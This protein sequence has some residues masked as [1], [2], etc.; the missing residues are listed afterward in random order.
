MIEIVKIFTNAWSYALSRPSEFGG[1]LSDH[2]WLVTIALGISIVICIP[3]GVW[4]SRSRWAPNL[5]GL[6]LLLKKCLRATEQ[7]F[8]P[9]A[10]VHLSEH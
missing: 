5:G 10:R 6:A 2:L 7:Y 8:T 4:T 1:A 9:Q 3:L